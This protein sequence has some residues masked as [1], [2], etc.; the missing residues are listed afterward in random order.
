M[1]YEHIIVETIDNGDGAL[2]TALITLN[3]P[4]KYNALNHQL[5]MDIHNAIAH[6]ESDD[7]IGATLVTGAGDKAFAAGGDIQEMSEF[8][9]TK[10]YKENFVTNGWEAIAHARKPVIAVVNGL[11]L[12][13]G[14]ELTM[15]CDTAIASDTATFGQPEIT[16]GFLPGMGGTQRLARAVGKAMAMDMVLTGKTLNANEALQYGIVA[17]VVPADELLDT[18]KKM[19]K[20]ICGY[21]MPAV[22]L[23]KESVD[24]AFETT[25]SMGMQVERRLVH[26]SFSLADQ[27]EGMDAFLQK[28][29]PNFKHQ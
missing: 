17:R 9:F 15:M 14:C 7:S 16:L 28:R 8:T 29:K 24:S 6:I 27:K 2:K 4:D 1:T 25:L 12:G 13:G 3:R 21:S 18:A 26:A 5:M 11:A 20:T 22:M 23:A 19:A 10:A